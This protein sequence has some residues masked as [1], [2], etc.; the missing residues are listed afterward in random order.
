MYVF[1]KVIYLKVWEMED[2]LPVVVKRSTQV[3][4]SHLPRSFQN[5]GVNKLKTLTK[6]VSGIIGNNI[7]LARGSVTNRH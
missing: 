4:L 1:G 6:F 2:G 7:Y 3:I 5:I